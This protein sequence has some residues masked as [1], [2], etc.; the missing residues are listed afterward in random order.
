MEQFFAT[1]FLA[2]VALIVACGVGFS[3]A[4][5]FVEAVKSESWLSKVLWLL[6]CL[7]LPAAF[8]AFVITLS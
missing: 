4:V 8:M 5:C 2:I 1:F 6:A 7:A 3:G